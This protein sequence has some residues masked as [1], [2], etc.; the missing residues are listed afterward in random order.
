MTTRLPQAFATIAL[1]IV[2]C[3]CA[4]SPRYACGVPSG[5]SCKSVRAVYQ[6][7]VAGVPTITARSDSSAHAAPAS[8]DTGKPASADVPAA[9]DPR[10]SPP[11]QLRVWIAR[12]EDADGDLVG[13]SMLY[14]RLDRG[15]W[16]TGP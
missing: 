16:V 8:S 13:E 6:A 4:S 1:G 14:L 11:R 2:L 12:W 3:A 10:L 15:T 7:S 5:V 9:G